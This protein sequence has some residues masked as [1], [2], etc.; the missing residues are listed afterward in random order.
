MHRALHLVLMVTGGEALCH[1]IDQGFYKHA[2][3]PTQ[4][5]LIRIHVFGF[6]GFF[7]FAEYLFSLKNNYLLWFHRNLRS[8]LLGPFILLS[9]LVFLLVSLFRLTPDYL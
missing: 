4:I 7:F 3:S 5:S 2:E 9:R 6:L 1:I 8:Y